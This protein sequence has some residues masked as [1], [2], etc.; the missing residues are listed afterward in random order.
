MSR[1][2]SGGNENEMSYAQIV[3]SLTIGFIPLMVWVWLREYREMTARHRRR[4][5]EMTAR[6]RRELEE[7]RWRHF[8]AMM[9]VSYWDWVDRQRIE[10]GEEREVR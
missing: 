3:V 2:R 4:L 1:Q 5:E 6:H 9:R 10:P 8:E 7:M